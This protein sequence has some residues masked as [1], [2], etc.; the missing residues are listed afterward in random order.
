[1][2]WHLKNP[3][4]LRG[5]CFSWDWPILRNSKVFI[6]WLHLIYKLPSQEPHSFC[7]AHPSGR[8]LSS[9]LLILGPGTRQLE[10]TAIAQSLLKLF[11]LVSPKLFSQSCLAFPT[12]TP[13]RPWFKP[14]I[15]SCLLSSDHSGIFPRWLWVKHRPPVSGTCE[16]NINFVFSWVSPFSPLMTTPDWPSHK[17]IQNKVPKFP[18]H[19]T[20][21]WQHSS[22]FT[23]SAL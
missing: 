10:T 16:H 15:H 1:M 9:A 5:K 23:T 22:V 17:G 8:K 19:L 20:S 7:L 4:C 13:M 14:S 11:Q 12:K 6:R 21:P 18:K 2:F 3:S